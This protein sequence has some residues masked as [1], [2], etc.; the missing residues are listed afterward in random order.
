MYKFQPRRSQ[1][2]RKYRSLEPALLRFLLGAIIITIVTAWVLAA[3]GSKAIQ[4][5][6]V[7]TATVAAASLIYSLGRG[8]AATKDQYTMTLI[9]KRFDDGG[10]A[11]NVRKASDLRQQKIVTEQTSLAW[12]LEV[13]WVDPHDA[14]KRLRAAHA[15]IPILNYWE[16]VCTAYVD[17][18]INRQI[19]EDLVQD[20]I[21][22]LVGRYPKII[23]DMR[24]EDATNLEH[25]CA[26][27]FVLAT[28]EEHR[29]L[30]P[31]L[32]PSPQR[33]APHDQD[34]WAQ[35]YPRR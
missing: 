1:V 35:A 8:Q 4:P 30:V 24:R 20:L 6:S 5:G 29:L 10:Y 22:D 19:F 13:E 31:L 14:S 12:L 18:R 32:G 3:A 33:L 17:D 27:W 2:E 28:G 25:L 16:H 15:I 21:R 7:L 11:D 26:V 9:A 23:G 34:L